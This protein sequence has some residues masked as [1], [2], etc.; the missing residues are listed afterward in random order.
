[1]IRKKLT[2]RKNT[3]ASYLIYNDKDGYKIGNLIWDKTKTELLTLY[4]YTTLTINVNPSDAKITFDAGEYKQN[5][6][7]ISVPIG[8]EVNYKIERDGY[9]PI[10]RK[11]IVSSD[12][13]LN[14]DLIELVTITIEPI[15]SNA[16]V[17][18][19]FIE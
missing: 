5:G 9:V 7:S 10:E 4:A 17:T 8:T 6:N 12:T 11:L 16:V 19:T 15:P 13:E 14:I 18:I 3:S 1:M 2:G